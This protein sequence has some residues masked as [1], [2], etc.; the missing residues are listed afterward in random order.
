MTTSDNITWVVTFSGNTDDG[1]D[2]FK[3]VK[4]GV[5]DLTIDGSKVH[6]MGAP[7]VNMEANATTTFHR[8]FG[9]SNAATTPIG[10]TPGTD[11]QAIVNTSDNL[12]FRSAFNNPLN[13][14]AF[15][16]LRP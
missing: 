14:Q 3:S 15:F 11:F 5:Y 13:Y 9:D 8:L 4:D 6:P 10:G 16:D 1:S 2:G 12:A 7:G